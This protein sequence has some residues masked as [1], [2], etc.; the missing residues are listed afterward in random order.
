MILE[1]EES[2]LRDKIIIAINDEALQQRL[3][4]DSELTLKK[5]MENCRA[6]ELSSNNEP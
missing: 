3:L 4:R 1:Q 2:L 6:A 5:A